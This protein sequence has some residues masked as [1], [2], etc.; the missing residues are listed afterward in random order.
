MNEKD[1]ARILHINEAV[2]FIL[3]H[4]KDSY[5]STLLDDLVLRYAIERQL[6]IIG[7][8][9]SFLSEDLKNRYAE[10][11][12]NKIKQFRNFLAHEHFGIDYSLVWDIIENKIPELQ[13][14]ISTIIQENKLLS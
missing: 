9:V 7:E 2:F 1:K 11:E 12:W 10:T 3:H 6:E 5:E 14:T 4:K 13:I 8:A